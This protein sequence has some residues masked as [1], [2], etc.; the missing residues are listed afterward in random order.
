MPNMSMMFDPTSKVLLDQ[1]ETFTSTG[2]TRTYTWGIADASKPVRITMAYVDAPGS[3]TGNPQ[4]NN[5]DLTVDGRRP[6]LSR[7]P[8]DRQFQHERR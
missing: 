7:Q 2:D 5:I 8:H 3:T 1:S 6:D 4:V